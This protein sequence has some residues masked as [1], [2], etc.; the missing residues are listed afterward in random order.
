[1]RALSTRDPDARIRRRPATSMTAMTTAAGWI[2]NLFSAIVISPTFS[3]GAATSLGIPRSLPTASN[4][5]SMSFR[6]GRNR[7]FRNC[8]RQFAVRE[9][10][11][12]TRLGSNLPSHINSEACHLG[13]VE[14]V[15]D[16][17]D[18]CSERPCP[19]P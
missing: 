8:E 6:L 4:P 14:T 5:R 11:V 17:S 9:S 13:D 15:A 18:N 3:V 12:R 2:E 7:H 1:V 19:S 10:R 16:A